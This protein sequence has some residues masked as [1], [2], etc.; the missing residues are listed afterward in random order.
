MRSEHNHTPRLISVIVPV[1]NMDKYLGAAI[2][3]ILEQTYKPVEILVIDDGSNDQSAKVAK[4]FV[5]SIHYFYQDNQG[6]GAARNQGISLARGNYLAF[7][8]A[9]DTWNKTRLEHQIQRFDWD[10]SVEAVFGSADEFYSPELT[11]E[12]REN[13]RPPRNMQPAYMSTAMLI[14]REA[15]LRVGWFKTGLRI[16]NDMEWYLRAQESGLKSVMIPECV[17]QRRLHK[18]NL[19]IVQQ[20]H[21]KERVQLLKK[22][23]DRRRG[24][25]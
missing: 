1:Y 13:I 12:E 18:N 3:S 25:P 4:D 16:G 9:D 8:D 11:A 20:A 22:A 6:L 14:K 23:L 5:P 21:A 2:E 17:L 19:G 7:L 24:K 15:F 10:H